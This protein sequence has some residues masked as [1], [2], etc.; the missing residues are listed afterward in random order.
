MFPGGGGGM[1]MQEGEDRIVGK[2][3]GGIEVPGDEKR[4]REQEEKGKEVERKDAEKG[5]KSTEKGAEKEQGRGTTEG[6]CG[7]GEG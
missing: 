7:R 4:R 1:E 2:G 5:N 6:E 3:L